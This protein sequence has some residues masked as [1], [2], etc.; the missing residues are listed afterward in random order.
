MHACMTVYM[1]TY[2]CEEDD[3]VALRFF[4]VHQNK[5][6]HSL[7]SVYRVRLDHNVYL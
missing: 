6:R 7:M 2:I 1:S 4:T 5:S 3:D